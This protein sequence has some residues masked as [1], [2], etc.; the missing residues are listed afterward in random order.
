MSRHAIDHF[1]IAADPDYHAIGIYEGLGFERVELIVG[2]MLSQPSGNVLSIGQPQ[3]RVCAHPTPMT[4]NS[5][6]PSANLRRRSWSALWRYGVHPNA[7]SQ[8]LAPTDRTHRDTV[9]IAA[10]EQAALF[11]DVAG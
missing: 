11:P 8:I 1:V 10:L 4:R 5:S 3:R 6:W 9:L 2:A 7:I